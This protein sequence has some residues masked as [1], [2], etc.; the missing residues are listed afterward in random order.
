[1][2]TFFNG[3]TIVNIKFVFT[4]PSLCYSVLDCPEQTA[5]FAC[6]SIHCV[7]DISLNNNILNDCNY[8]RFYTYYEMSVCVYRAAFGPRV[9][10]SASDW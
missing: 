1:M 9:A 3:C 7:S 4:L 2:L 5:V 8:G 6:I 10:L